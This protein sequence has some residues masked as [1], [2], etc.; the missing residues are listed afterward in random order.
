MP[1]RGVY[2]AARFSNDRLMASSYTH[3]TAIAIYQAIASSGKDGINIHQ[4]TDLTGLAKNTVRTYCKVMEAD[5]AI[6]ILSTQSP[7]PNRPL[8]NLYVAVH[9]PLPRLSEYERLVRIAATLKGISAKNSKAEMMTAIQ[10]AIQITQ[11]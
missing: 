8:M 11:G 3:T 7:A 5:G 1:D 9:E 4:L 2:D 10:Q 6:A